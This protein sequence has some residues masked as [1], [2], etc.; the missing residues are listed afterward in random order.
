MLPQRSALAPLVCWT[1]MASGAG[2]ASK[3]ADKWVDCGSQAIDA[4][5]LNATHCRC[6]QIVARVEAV[7]AAERAVPVAQATRAATRQ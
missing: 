1:C 5:T 2:I 6:I 3:A 4:A 7:A